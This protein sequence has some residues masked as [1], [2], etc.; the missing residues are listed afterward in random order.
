MNNA[1]ARS[2]ATAKARIQS[3]ITRPNQSDKVVYETQPDITFS[4]RNCDQGGILYVENGN[5]K[6]RGPNGTT[7]T[8]A[9]A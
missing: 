1:N 2:R 5:L 8:I 7:T 6:Y 4:N 3:T 9:V